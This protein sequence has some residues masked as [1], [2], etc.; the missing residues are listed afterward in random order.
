MYL[1]GTCLGTYLLSLSVPTPYSVGTP[2]GYIVYARTA[3]HRC[4]V[5]LVAAGSFLRPVLTTYVSRYFGTYS[6]S[7]SM[8]GA[9][10]GVLVQKKRKKISLLSTPN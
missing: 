4:N 6:Y 3:R 5:Q 9:Y 7:V 8:L 1:V 2:Y 10:G